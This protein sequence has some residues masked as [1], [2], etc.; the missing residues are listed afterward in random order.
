MKGNKTTTGLESPKVQGK[1]VKD[2]SN[3]NSAEKRAE[4]ATEASEECGP[5]G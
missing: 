5:A 1:E 3:N 2:D 4:E